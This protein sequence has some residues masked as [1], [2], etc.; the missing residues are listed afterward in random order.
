MYVH[1]RSQVGAYLV[2][3][4][5]YLVDMGAYLVDMGAYLVGM[6]ARHKDQLN[7]TTYRSAS[8]VFPFT[9]VVCPNHAGGDGAAQQVGSSEGRSLSSP[10]S[11]STGAKRRRVDGSHAGK[12][13]PTTANKA[14]QQAAS[15]AAAAASRSAEADA[16]GSHEDVNNHGS[17]RSSHDAGHGETKCGWS[18]SFGDLLSKHLALCPLQPVCCPCGAT[19]LRNRLD[20]HKLVSCP[21]SLDV[22]EICDA[23]MKSAEMDAHMKHH[24][25][26]HVRLLQQR[27]RA[28]EARAVLSE[29]NA[30]ATNDTR[31]MRWA[32][33]TLDIWGSNEPKSGDKFLSPKFTLRGVSGFQLSFFPMGTE[34]G[35]NCAVFLIGPGGFWVQFE[36]S[37]ELLDALGEPLNPRALMEKKTTYEFKGG[38][39]DNGWHNWWSVEKVKAA[40]QCLIIVEVVEICLISHEIVRG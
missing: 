15:S 8:R 11:A 27:V 24:A 9:K 22:C 18:G 40:S 5:A 21:S 31:R 32:F 17:A 38:D 20:S 30:A 14:P 12:V 3:M 4:G 25:E 37:F 26:F 35:K 13:T 39:D 28:A 33:K 23:R 16:P 2:D 6:H 19:V 34:D 36:I 7:A 29:R 1:T 10:A